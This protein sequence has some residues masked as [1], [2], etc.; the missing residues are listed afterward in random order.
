[1]EKERENELSMI[2]LQKLVDMFFYF[3]NDNYC[4][5]LSQ[6][7]IPLIKSITLILESI[8]SI[9]NIYKSKCNINEILN[10][11]TVTCISMECFMYCRVVYPLL[12]TAI[13]L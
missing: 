1:M 4:L 9:N 5:K 6:M 12:I 10:N 13:V 11:S 3:G 8:T 2:I 7:K